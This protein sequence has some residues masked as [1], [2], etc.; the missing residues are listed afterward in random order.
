MNGPD[1][2]TEIQDLFFELGYVWVCSK[3]EITNLDATYIYAK[4]GVLTAGFNDLN[5][6]EAGHQELTLP[7]LRDL[8]VLH[9]NDV[10]DANWVTEGDDQ[11]YKDSNGK[12]FIFREQGWDELQRHE[13]RQAMWEKI[14]P[15]P[16]PTEHEQGLISGA[17]QTIK[18]NGLDFLIEGK[19]ALRS[20]LDGNDI[21]L[22][23]EPW[24][25]NS[26]SDFNPTEDE[27]STKAFFT[28]LSSDGQK[29]FFRL[30]P[31]TIKLELEIPAPMNRQPKVGERCCYI[32][33]GLASGYQSLVWE[34]DFSDFIDLW[35]NLESNAEQAV[36]AMR[37]IKG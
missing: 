6:A 36:A 29:V 5:F 30:K 4:D 17:E 8:V 37:G 22:S 12:L 13:M 34:E 25:V 19:D 35:W 23:L 3:E 26:W 21:Q 10:S 9:R 16:Q 2:S 24:E 20:A 15:K 28:G 31:R 18:V 27:A 7:Q 32:D 1:N 11:I 33:F 14:K